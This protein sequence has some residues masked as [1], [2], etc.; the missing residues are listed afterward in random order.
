VQQDLTFSDMNSEES[1]K[2]FN[3]FVRRWNAGKLDE[4][5]A[6]CAVFAVFGKAQCKPVPVIRICRSTIEVGQQLT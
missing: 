3:K 5:C 4:V 1:R 2:M 6:V